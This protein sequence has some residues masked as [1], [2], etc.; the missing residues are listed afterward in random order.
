MRV[1]PCIGIRTDQLVD[2]VGKSTELHVWQFLKLALNCK[3]CIV[4]G[5]STSLHM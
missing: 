3:E 1:H 4:G 5:N 2:H